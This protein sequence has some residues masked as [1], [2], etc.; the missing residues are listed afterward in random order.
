MPRTHYRNG[1]EISLQHNGCDGCSPCMINGVLCHESGC[2]DAFRDVPVECW[3]CGCECF[4]ESAIQ[5]HTLCEDCN[6]ANDPDPETVLQPSLHTI[7]EY[8][9]LVLNEVDF[10]GI[11]VSDLQSEY[12]DDPEGEFIGEIAD[13]ALSRLADAGFDYAEENDA[14]LIYPR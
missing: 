10:R 1:D 12:D 6:G 13:D 4:R 5:T 14:L 11:D 3:E 9:G 8:V 7:S 2:P